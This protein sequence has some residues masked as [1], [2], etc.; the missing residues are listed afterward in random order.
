MFA[1]TAE[2]LSQGTRDINVNVSSLVSDV[3]FY[4]VEEGST[5]STKKMI[6]D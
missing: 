3:H 1:L 5:T 4:N 6:V 2:Q